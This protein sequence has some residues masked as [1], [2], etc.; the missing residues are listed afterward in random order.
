MNEI[1]KILLVEDNEEIVE[2]ISIALKIRWP[3]INITATCK[4]EEGI[5]LV[6]QENPDVV[7]LD[8]GL[9]DISGYNVLK[10]IRLF[11]DVPVMMLTARGEESDIVKGLELGADE[12]IVKPFKQLE[13]LSRLKVITR[14]RCYCCEELPISKGKFILN[15]LDRTLSAGDEIINLTKTESVLLGKLMINEGNVVRYSSLAAEIWGNDYPDAS[16]ALKVYIRRLRDKIEPS[17]HHPRYILTRS[18]LGY[19]FSIPQ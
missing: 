8:I 7:I 14:R 3:Q 2:A 1:T 19:M 5:S 6:E 11:S 16:A 17:P 10:A 18:G 12:Y 13:L 4:G 15:P 9:P